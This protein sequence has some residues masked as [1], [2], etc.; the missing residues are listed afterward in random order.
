MKEYKY[1]I[2]GNTYNVSIGDIVDNMT[3]VLVN[4][5]PY[6]VE[7]EKKTSPVT[8]VAPHRPS[9]APRTASGEKVVAKA[10]GAGGSYE[11]KAPLPGTILSINVKV[12]DSVKASDTVVVLEAMKMEN[13]IHAGKD[14]K[15]T[16]IS[17]AAGDAVLEGA[18]LISIG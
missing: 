9:A 3:E 4:G 7:L 14:G 11:V 13:A 12:G 16:G 1:K 10:A 6:R 18:V 17:V 8:V 5:T 2:N 15:V